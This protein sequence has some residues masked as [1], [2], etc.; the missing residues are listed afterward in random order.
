MSLSR[1]LLV[2]EVCNVQSTFRKT[3][4]ANLLVVSD[5][6]LDCSFKVK[7]RWARIKVLITCLLLFLEVCDVQ[8]ILRKSYAANL[9]VVSDLTLDRSFKV[10]IEWVRIKVP[11]T[12]LSLVLEVCNIQSLNQPLGSLFCES[13]GGVR[14]D[15]GPLLLGQ[16]KAGQD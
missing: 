7:Q 8:S 9:L 16:T 13:F 3:Y 10:K 1:L 6:T 5:L 11:I 12:R 2:L 15:L 4:A 14:F